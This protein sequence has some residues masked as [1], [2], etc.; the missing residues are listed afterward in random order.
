MFGE[1]L[2]VNLILSQFFK[3]LMYFFLSLTVFTSYSVTGNYLMQEILT[4]LIK[5]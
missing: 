3:V 1:D 2:K 5:I 4:S